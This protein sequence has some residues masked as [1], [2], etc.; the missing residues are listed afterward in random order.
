MNVCATCPARLT[1]DALD[2]QADFAEDVGAA[3]SAGRMRARAAEIRAERCTWLWEIKEENEDTGQTRTVFGCGR[4]YLPKFLRSYG[5][6]LARSANVVREDHQEIA[7]AVVT[8]SGAMPRRL[9]VLDAGAVGL[10]AGDA[11]EVPGGGDPVDQVAAV[12]HGHA[13][14]LDAPPGLHRGE[15]VNRDL[16]S[17]HR[18]R[19]GGAAIFDGEPVDP[20]F[21]VE[22]PE[23]YTGR[24][25]RRRLGDV[26]RPVRAERSDGGEEARRDGE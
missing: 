5:M 3:A 15:S 8:L 13:R 14:N 19:P 6:D 7:R 10:L 25:G 21:Q 26:D 20:A 18:D 22:L 23:G 12:E 9:Q 16:D 17:C 1:A 4:A 24:G 11:D 2:L